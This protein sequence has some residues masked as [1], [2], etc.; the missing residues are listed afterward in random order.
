VSSKNGEEEGHEEE[1][2]EEEGHQEEEVGRLWGG[3]VG[4]SA[5]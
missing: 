1:G 4:S 3:V 2:N 5:G